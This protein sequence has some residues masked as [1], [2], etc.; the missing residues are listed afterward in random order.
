MRV[1]AI[2]T[3][4]HTGQ[5]KEN[6]DRFITCK[7][8]IDSIH[9]RLRKTETD[10]GEGANGASA[11]VVTHAVEEATPPLPSFLLCLSPQIQLRLQPIRFGN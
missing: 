4:T 7:N 3:Y 9:D 6:F 8:T 10:D 5:V 11:A 2:L 1:I